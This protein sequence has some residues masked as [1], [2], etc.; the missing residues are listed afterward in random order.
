[1]RRIA[2]AA[3]LVVGV[4]LASAAIA[5]QFGPAQYAL[6]D[7]DGDPITNFDLSPQLSARLAK[8]PAQVPVGN[9]QGDVTLLQFYD[10]NCPFCRE[11][12]AD[13][14]TLVRADKKLK[15]VFVPY[16]VLSVQS[17][18]G[19][20]VETAAARMLT[21]EKYLEFHKRIYASRGTID[22]PRVLAAAEDVGLD[23]PQL[24]S[25][26]N[27]ETTLENLK[28]NAAFGSAAQLVATPAYVINGVVILGHP[29]LRPLQDLIR[30]VRACGKVVC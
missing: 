21:P 27:A 7:D 12:A 23:A 6:K 18:Q 25:I 19:A 14:D 28:Q 15:L 5:A 24:A 4:L 2:T 9:L 1:M 10:L 11:A 17:I 26:A 16:A 20:L 13:V 30:A 8:L 29:G 3:A 22:A